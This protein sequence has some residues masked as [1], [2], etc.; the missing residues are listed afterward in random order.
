MS[1]ETCADFVVGQRLTALNL[2]QAF[3]DFP[4]EP[5]VVVK[6]ARDCL[7]HQRLCVG[8]AL[9]RK[10][11]EFGLLPGRERHFHGPTLP[12]VGHGSDRRTRCDCRLSPCVNVR[13]APP[14]MQP[15]R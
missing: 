4:R 6:Q 13:F 11:R 12:E 3:L 2:R 15:A 8:P 5:I 7:A 9:L 14:R 10:A 1:A